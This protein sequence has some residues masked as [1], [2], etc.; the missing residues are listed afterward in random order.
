[1]IMDIMT[2]CRGA[3]LSSRSKK[4]GKHWAK[5]TATLR[6][7]LRGEV[8]RVMVSTWY[9]HFSAS[10][11][12]LVVLVSAFVMVSLQFG[13]FLVC[14]SFTHGAPPCPAI[15]KSGGMCPPCPMES[16]PCTALQWQWHC[17]VC[18]RLGIYPMLTNIF[19][20]P[21]QKP[22]YWL[23]AAGPLALT[24]AFR[25]SNHTVS[26]FFSFQPACLWRPN[27]VVGND[28]NTWSLTNLRGELGWSGYHPP[29]HIIMISYYEI[30]ADMPKIPKKKSVAKK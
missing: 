2:Q 23:A 10:K 1:M 28:G 14:C 30:M 11:A 29:Q 15:C 16:A 13:Q 8:G 3:I 6:Q 25:Y 26:V 12:Q 22:N 18:K 17:S 19:V 21:L 24:V 27:D 9:A 4:V 5:V 20:H 7:D